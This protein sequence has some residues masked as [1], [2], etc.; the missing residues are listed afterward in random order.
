MVN[1]WVAV[2]AIW[3]DGEAACLDRWINVTNMPSALKSQATC[4]DTVTDSSF[5]AQIKAQES[6][7]FSKP[8]MIFWEHYARGSMITNRLVEKSLQ[9][10]LPTAI[11][12]PN[13]T[14]STPVRV[15]V[16]VTTSVSCVH[17][18][19]SG[20]SQ[21]VRLTLF[22][23]SITFCLVDIYH[24]RWSIAERAFI[25]RRRKST[26]V[27]PVRD[28]HATEPDKCLNTCRKNNTA[29]LPFGYFFLFA[30]CCEDR[31]NPKRNCIWQ[32]SQWFI[33]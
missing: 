7:G 3:G 28:V 14:F 13:R 20:V 4:N 6:A 15:V 8:L 2:F 30:S 32:D 26:A 33:Y 17:F 1:V 25:T 21:P 31:N 19:F 22:F 5:L 27:Q 9:A 29:S 16:A 23:A 10:F 12:T 18:F 24:Q 11:T